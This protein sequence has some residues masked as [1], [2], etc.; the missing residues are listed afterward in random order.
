MGDDF[1]WSYLV[2]YI[3]VELITKIISY[4]IVEAFNL[5]D[6]GNYFDLCWS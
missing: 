4:D 2:I 3:G 1:I 6:Q 5:V